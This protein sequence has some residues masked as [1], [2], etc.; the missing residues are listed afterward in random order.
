M[1]SAHESTSERKTLQRESAGDTEITNSYLNNF[2]LNQLK[3]KPFLGVF[4]CDLM[5]KKIPPNKSLILNTDPHFQK[6]NHYVCIS[7]DTRGEY[8][9]FDP[10]ALDSQAFFPRMTREL[11]SRK[12]F[13]KLKPVCQSPIQSPVSKFCG[14]FCADYVM[15]QNITKMKK[16]NYFTRENKLIE[17]DKV[18]LENIML[19]IKKRK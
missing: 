8:H 13:P 7:R 11:K 1:S 15:T 10:L 19:N 3:I 17:N 2:L 5:P 14:L 12:I 16:A 18:C 9:Y 6:G 4:P